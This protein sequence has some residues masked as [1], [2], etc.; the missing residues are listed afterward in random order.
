MDREQWTAETWYSIAVELETA[1]RKKSLTAKVRRSLAVR[2]EAAW[3][4]G[5][6]MRGISLA[7]WEEEC[8]VYQAEDDA[9]VARNAAN[10]AVGIPRSQLVLELA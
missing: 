10:T 1:S 3:T 9:M 4:T 5:D 8:R 7:M 2:A 6:W